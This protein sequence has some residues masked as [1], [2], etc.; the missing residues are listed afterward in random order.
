MLD[1]V[2]SEMLLEIGLDDATLE[3]GVK[4]DAV[5]VRG[6]LGIDPVPEESTLR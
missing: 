1:E 5:P 3:L 6:A 2:V 4:V